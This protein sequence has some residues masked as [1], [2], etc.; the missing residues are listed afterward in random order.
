MFSWQI[1]GPTG[2]DGNNLLSLL[3]F[4]FIDSANNQHLKTNMYL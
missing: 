1:S 2:G 4:H 3:F